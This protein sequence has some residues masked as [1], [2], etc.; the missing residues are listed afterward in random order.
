[1][2]HTRMT[3]P[4]PAMTAHCLSG[5]IMV[6]MQAIRKLADRG[7]LPPFAACSSAGSMPRGMLVSRSCRMDN[8]NSE[9]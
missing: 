6:A 2:R 3:A 7:P 1:M 5:S 8:M 4:L 9:A